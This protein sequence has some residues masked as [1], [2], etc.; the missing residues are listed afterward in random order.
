MYLLLGWVIQGT[1]NDF[2]LGY[3][4]ACKGF[5]LFTASWV[6]VGGASFVFLALMSLTSLRGLSPGGRS[7]RTLLVNVFF[8]ALIL[9]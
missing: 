2:D 5:G 9:L 8:A 1:R 4:K 6:V 7:H 3:M